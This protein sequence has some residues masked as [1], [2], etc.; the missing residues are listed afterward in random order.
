MFT[1]R[2]HVIFILIIQE[3]TKCIYQKSNWSTK[4]ILLLSK[5]Y[6]VTSITIKE[7]KHRQ[8]RS[9]NIIATSEPSFLRNAAN[10][11]SLFYS[12]LHSYIATSHKKSSKV[13]NFNTE[14]QKTTTH[15]GKVT[16]SSTSSTSVYYNFLAR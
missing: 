12:Y 10:T 14:T 2:S 11:Y 8:V 9:Y 15:C 13:V 7:N 16:H 6:P 1:F 4:V 5:S 3:S